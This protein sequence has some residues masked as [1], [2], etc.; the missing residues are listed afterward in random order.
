[1]YLYMRRIVINYF[2]LPYTRVSR[3]PEVSA[4]RTARVKI[5]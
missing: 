4:T 5:V 2:L 1:M 3:K